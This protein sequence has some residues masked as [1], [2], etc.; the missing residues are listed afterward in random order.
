MGD[1]IEIQFRGGTP[2]KWLPRFVLI[3]ECLSGHAVMNV[4]AVV[5]PGLKVLF[6]RVGKPESSVRRGGGTAN[7]YEALT[8]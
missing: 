1:G 8:S 5:W 3:K 6:E 2:K 4:L 7:K